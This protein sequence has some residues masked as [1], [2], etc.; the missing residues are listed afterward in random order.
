M[1]EVG[2]GVSHFS[3]DTVMRI[4]RRYAEDRIGEHESEDSVGK[5]GCEEHRGTSAGICAQ[6]DRSI[7]AGSVHDGLY[8]GRRLV[9]PCVAWC[10][11]RSGETSGRMH[12]RRACPIGSTFRTTSRRMYRSK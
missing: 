11:V 3:R 9:H 5:R 12:P 10:S 2:D 8:V 7:A 4:R 6:Q 1:G